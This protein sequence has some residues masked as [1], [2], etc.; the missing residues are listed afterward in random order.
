MEWRTKAA[1]IWMHF[2]E[3]CNFCA[4]AYINPP[5]TECCSCMTINEKQAY[6]LQLYKP[7]HDQF[8]RFCRARVYG[9]M[10]HSDL[11]N[12]TLLLA[13]QKLDSLQSEG[14]F[15]SFLIG[16][17]V[18]LLA[19]QQR[20]KKEDPLPYSPDFDVPDG[21]AN[22]EREAE[23]YLLEKAFAMLP[24][25]QRESVILFEISGFSIKEICVMQ[26]ASESAVK[27]RIRRGRARLRE[28]LTFESKHKTK[29]VK[30][31]N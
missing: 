24:D 25:D 10:E 2:G 26:N 29:E 22:A 13:F 28:I 15:L 14:V 16:I 21:H 23:V 18:R 20:K 7:V 4:A 31:G 3:R 1:R 9:K 17:S 8:E 12:E 30:H 19:N 6:F 11:M 27:Q 5:S